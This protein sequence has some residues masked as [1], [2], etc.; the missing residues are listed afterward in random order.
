M[1]RATGFPIHSTDSPQANSRTPG[2]RDNVSS[3]K[4]G[5]LEPHFP[6][7]LPLCADNADGVV[8]NVAAP[9]E[10]GHPPIEHHSSGIS[11]TSW[12]D[13]DGTPL[14]QESSMDPEIVRLLKAT[15]AG[16]ELLLTCR[17]NFIDAGATIEAPVA[18][19]TA[20]PWGC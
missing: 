5:Y 1:G 2:I 11:L 7:S 3:R 18:I 20:P 13:V 8:V 19:S 10:S 17:M 6:A 15:D 14:S 9:P 4:A 16:G 12:S